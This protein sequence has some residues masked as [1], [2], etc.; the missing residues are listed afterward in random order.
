[1]NAPR[2]LLESCRHDNRKAHFELYKVCFPV[3]YSLCSRYYIN[4]DDR[5]SAVNMIFLKLIQSMNQY[6]GKN[7][8]M[9]FEVWSRK[10]AVNY[11]IDEFRKSKKYRELISFHDDL[12]TEQFIH[13]ETN[14][15]YNEKELLEVI[16]KLPVASRTVFNLY[17]IDGY[18]HE[19]IS[20]LLGISSGTSK[21]HL[22]KARKKIRELL[23]EL[24]QH[25]NIIKSAYHDK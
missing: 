15:S 14:Q 11:I 24:H 16:D 13:D 9:P 21:S 18:R 1:M 3:I 7:E 19:E 25:S 5:L 8:N 22:F 10:V 6:L 23:A 20:E 2:E 12:P 4:K 17:A